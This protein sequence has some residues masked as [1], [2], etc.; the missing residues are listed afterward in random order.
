MRVVDAAGAVVRSYDYDAFGVERAPDAEDVNPWRYCGEYFDVETG[1][2]YLR[3]RYYNPV[4]G[5]FLTEDP[6]GDGLNWYTYTANNPI[7]YVD[8]S[9]EVKVSSGTVT[10]WEAWKKMGVMAASIG[11]S[12]AGIVGMCAGVVAIVGG[13]A[14]YGALFAI[15]IIFEIALTS[16]KAAYDLIFLCI[17]MYYTIEYGGFNYEEVGLTGLDVID[18][19]V[20]GAMIGISPSK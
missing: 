15:P 17:A 20:T 10:G 8:P 6:I 16:T 11:I 5:R 2:I 1:T 9:G 19:L 14:G 3:A 18:S 12:I 4:T 13:T 7:M